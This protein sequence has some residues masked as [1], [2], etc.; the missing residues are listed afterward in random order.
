MLAKR[1]TTDGLNPLQLRR[2]V[3]L[4]I[5]ADDYLMKLLVLK[6]GTAL[7]LVHLPGVRAS[8][9]IDYSMEGD[10]QSTEAVHDLERRLSSA[11]TSRL[12]KEGFEVFDLSFRPKPS[13]SK[14][15]SR[16]GGYRLE[17]KVI[18]KV[19]FERLERSVDALRRESIALN[20]AHDRIFSVDISKFE[21]CKE[22]ELVPL[23]GEHVYVYTAPLM[24]AEK[25]RAICQQLPEYKH[26]GAER[27]RPRARDIFDIRK[28]VEKKNLNLPAVPDQREMVRHVFEAKEVPLE[29]L[30]RVEELRDFFLPDWADVVVT[31]GKGVDA[32]EFTEY[33]NFVRDLALRLHPSGNV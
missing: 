21:Y 30:V 13:T 11:V 23:A 17:F 12:A 31:V 4:A 5:A 7:E 16:W 20:A 32:T 27:R 33:F 24:V 18:A 2:L 25:L 19:D 28:L 8:I 22:R 3:V 6:G 14:P 10:V 26:I 15:G 9:D 29:Y 1:K